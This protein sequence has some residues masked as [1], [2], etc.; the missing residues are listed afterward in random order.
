MLKEI[1]LSKEISKEEYKKIME[2]LELKI[3]ELQ[4][5]I[6]KLKIPVIIVF[7]GWD[8]AGK[9]TLINKFILPLDPRDFNV[10]TMHKPN[11]EEKMKPFLWRFWTRT[12]EG[13]RTAVFDRSWYRKTFEDRVD[14]LIKENEVEKYYS[15]INSFERQLYD[16][17][18]IIIKFFIHI[19]EKEQK[20][21]LRKLQNNED[22]SWRVTEK[23]WKHNFQYE[24]YIKVFSEGIKAT[25]TEAAPWIVIEGTDRRY[26]TIKI[27]KTVIK[28]LEG[29]INN[30]EDKSYEDNNYI[31]KDGFK[32][33]E[34]IDFS[35]KDKIFL[36]D[37][38]KLESI[39]DIVDISKCME[40]EEYKRELKK[41]QK[42]IREIEYKIYKK[43]L[44]VIIVYEGW[45]AA[46]K[47][48]NIKRVTQNLDPRGYEVV[49]IAAPNEVEKSHHYLWR[50]WTKIP[51]A[52]HIT[53][54]DRSWYGRVLV[55][56]IEGFCSE[57][58]WKRAYKEIK[59]MEEN[60]AAFGGVVLKFWLHIDKDEQLRRF[61][62][63]LNNPHKVWKITEEDWRNREKW[64]SYKVAVDEMLKKTNADYAPW[65]V[66]EANNKYY[67]RIKVLKKIVETLEERL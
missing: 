23:D 36:D 7:E 61:N 32:H 59:E 44:P 63:R 35:N 2:N 14:D 8:A 46:G 28:I 65:T 24:D 1:D 55:E 54:F 47:G 37:E 11:E 12:P 25:N 18:N 20:K 17:G 13:G 4:R 38:K 60:M 53:I 27:F 29:R 40:K 45:D 3:A 62:A 57:E 16:D 67:A 66:V 51:K 42:R 49:S 10:Y 56:R 5:K 48:G 58:E 22:T 33:N 50:F 43:R 34:N 31:E 15:E 64:D 30:F 6:K 19:S 52:G 41:Y 39:L 9:G 26:A 21:R